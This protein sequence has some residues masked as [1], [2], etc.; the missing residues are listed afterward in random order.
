MVVGA[1]EPCAHIFSSNG[2]ANTFVSYLSAITCIKDVGGFV[3][4][5]VLMLLGVVAE[6]PYC[7][8]ALLNLGNIFEE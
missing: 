2:I 7:D 1:C 6:T 5:P 3:L 4:Q 8:G